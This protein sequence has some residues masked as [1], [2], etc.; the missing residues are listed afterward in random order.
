M[1]GC[2]PFIYDGYVDRTEDLFGAEVTLYSEQVA[3]SNILL[4]FIPERSVS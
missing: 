2:N 4:P 1:K 3:P